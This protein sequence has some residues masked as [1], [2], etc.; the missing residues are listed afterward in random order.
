M[1]QCNR[2]KRVFS[3]GINMAPG[4]SA[5]FIDNKTKCPFCGSWENIPDGTFRATVEGF[6]QVLRQSENPLS[7]AQELLDALQNTKTQNDL[8]ELKQSQKF[9]SLQK[10]L[11]TSLEKVGI[12]IAII[13]ALT[14]MLI[15]D[16]KMDIEYT[17]FIKE[18][19]QI[20]LESK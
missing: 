4:A 15:N 6:I 17:I 14:Q 16:P 3:S 11:P 2:C 7:K 5:T 18:Y 10:W 1:L 13:Y 20:I 8:K 19:N 9:K 12:Y